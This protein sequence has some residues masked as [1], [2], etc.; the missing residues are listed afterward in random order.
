[1]KDFSGKKK[2]DGGR[3]KKRGGESRKKGKE[4][5]HQW[6]KVKELQSFASHR[7]GALRRV[8][9]NLTGGGIMPV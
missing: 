1:M 4:G 7:E 3:R 9:R 8:S 5:G 6:G 2:I